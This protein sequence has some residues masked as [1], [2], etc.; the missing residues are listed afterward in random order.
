MHTN[1]AGSTI[2]GDTTAA[3]CTGGDRDR[4][5]ATAAVAAR[6]VVFSHEA[7][8]AFGAIGYEAAD[9]SLQERLW[10]AAIPDLRRLWKRS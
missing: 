9:P 10:Q 5:S 1:V 2:D 7:S 8:D 4:L 6:A 3:Q